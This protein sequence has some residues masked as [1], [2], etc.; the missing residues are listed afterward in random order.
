MATS[1]ARRGPPVRFEFV[2]CS[3]LELVHHLVSQKAAEEEMTAHYSLCETLYAKATVECD[4][5]VALWLGANVMLEYSYEEAMAMLQTN[6]ANAI[7][8]LQEANE[9]LDHLRNQII[10][11]EVNM[12]R[13]FNYD[14]KRRRELKAAGKEVPGAAAKPAIK[15]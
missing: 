9:D 4:G 11:I 12:S 3:T 14:V 7:A 13:T 5:T 15:A 10:T 8:K 1:R 6:I 2:L